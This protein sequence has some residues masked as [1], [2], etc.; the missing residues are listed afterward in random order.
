[1]PR[2]CS[3]AASYALNG[4]QEKAEE[5]V[6]RL[7]EK[8]PDFAKDPRA[9]YRAGGMPKELIDRLMEGLELAGYDVPP[10]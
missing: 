10:E 3:L 2:H 4:D 6:A 1:M 9:P 5:W 8:Y 7:R